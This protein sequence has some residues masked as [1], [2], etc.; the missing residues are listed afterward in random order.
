[1]KAEEARQNTLFW[2]MSKPI[3][4]QHERDPKGL[5][6]ALKGDKGYTGIDSPFE[7]PE[8]YEIYWIQINMMFWH[9]K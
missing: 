4:Y 1:M 6:K 8:Q 7:Q 3:G 2:Y 9:G 5:T